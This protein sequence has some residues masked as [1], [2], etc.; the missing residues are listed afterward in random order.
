VL[1][2][3]KSLVARARRA[4]GEAVPVVTARA[5][6]S[7]EPLRSQLLSLTSS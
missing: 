3:A 2:A 5:E 1:A 6:Q 7:A 4:K